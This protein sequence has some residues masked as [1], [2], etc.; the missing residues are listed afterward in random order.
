[1]AGQGNYKSFG[2]AAVIVYKL[3]LLGWIIFGLGYLIMLLEY[4]TRAMRS[5]KVVKLEQKL[6]EVLTNSKIWNGFTKD[7]GYLRRV[8]NELYLDKF[9]VILFDFLT[10]YDY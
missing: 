6:V 9:K 4:L 8:M 1:M 2:P 7:M 3:L 10:H 5:K